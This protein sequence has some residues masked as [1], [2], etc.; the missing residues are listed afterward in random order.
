MKINL[1]FAAIAL[2]FFSCQTNKGKDE[3]TELN[4]TTLVMEE[5]ATDEN[6]Q[7]V[8][9]IDHLKKVLDDQNV[10]LLSDCL[11]SP[12]RIEEI[13]LETHNNR[14]VSAIQASSN[15]LS[16]DVMKDNYETVYND[17]DLDLVHILLTEV[18]K[19][20]LAVKSQVTQTF[21]EGN[22]DYEG[23][24]SIKEQ[25]VKINI[26]SLNKETR[27][28]KDQQWKFRSNGEFLVLD[29]RYYL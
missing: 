11:D 26:R 21:K 19:E 10:S 25:E 27:C 13:E 16:S 18:E 14:L 2:S 1:L 8:I 28:K 17:L 22:C 20:E 24:L 29:R 23:H 6:K 12:K 4:K 15:R 5:A 9:E 7:M 3:V